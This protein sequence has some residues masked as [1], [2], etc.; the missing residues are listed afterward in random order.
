MTNEYME[1]AKRTAEKAG[2][3]ITR[4]YNTDVDIDF[5]GKYDLVTEIDFKSE[6]LIVNSIKE[7]YPEHDIVT[8]ETDWDKT[9]SDY[10]WYIDPISG[11]TN[12]SHS[13]PVFSVSIGLTLNDE[14]IAGAVFDP[15]RDELF[16][17]SNENGSYLNGDEIKV[18]DVSELEDSLIGTGFPYNI[19]ER[20]KNL[21]YFNSMVPEIQGIRRCGSVA[22]DLCHVA[23]GR[24]DGFWA[25]GL[26]PWDVSAGI[27]IL[28]EAGG[29]VSNIDRNNYG[30][31]DFD[32][33]ASNGHLHDTMSLTL[34]D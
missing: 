21:E 27:I 11:T 8:E 15:L 17:A 4:Y 28:E 25:V 18:S 26:K 12:Y 31:G 9:G 7:R 16:C 20:R 1:F 10:I 34:N 23:C 19:D 14:I 32:I 24:L 3:I 30:L 6:E 22:I 29:K 5:K 2:D 13:Y 33:L